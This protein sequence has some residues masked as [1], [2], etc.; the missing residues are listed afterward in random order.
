MNT[1]TDSIIRHI[2]RRLLIVVLLV[3]G[4]GTTAQWIDSKRVGSIIYLLADF[5]DYKISRYDC[6]AAAWLATIT[7][8]QAPTAFHVTETGFL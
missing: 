2:V 3:Q 6:D 4:S 8:P 1:E 5:P 7:L